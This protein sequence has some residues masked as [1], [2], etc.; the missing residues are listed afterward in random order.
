MGWEF[1]DVVECYG[2]IAMVLGLAPSDFRFTDGSGEIHNYRGGYHYV[3]VVL[4][5]RHGEPTSP[6]YGSPGTYFRS[7]E[8]P[9]NE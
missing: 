6:S 1:G 3:L 8:R 9:P 7:W 5:G 4:K 2:E